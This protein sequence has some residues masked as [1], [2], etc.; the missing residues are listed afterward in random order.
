[1]V[2]YTHFWKYNDLLSKRAS[3][4]A[5]FKNVRINF[6][7]DNPSIFSGENVIKSTFKN[8]LQLRK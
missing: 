4:V 1:M 7:A 8:E 2:S 3:D 5:I 6:Y